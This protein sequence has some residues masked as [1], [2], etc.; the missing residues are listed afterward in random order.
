MKILGRG[1]WKSGAG[2]LVDVW[3]DNDPGPGNCES[4]A[5]PGALVPGIGQAVGGILTLGK[6]PTGRSIP[7]IAGRGG[8]PTPG[9]GE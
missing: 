8:A 9:L 4:I 5:V 3:W 1:G 2:S 6:D 7:G